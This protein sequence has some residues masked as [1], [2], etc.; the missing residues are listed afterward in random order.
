MNAGSSYGCHA[1]KLADHCAGVIDGSA[2]LFGFKEP[3]G[4]LL[5]DALGYRQRQFGAIQS[6]V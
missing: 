3:A 2:Q 5:A 4:I 1:A 6:G